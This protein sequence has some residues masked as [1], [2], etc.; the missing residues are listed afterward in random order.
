[1][2]A[3]GVGDNLRAARAE[4]RGELVANIA[5]GRVKHVIGAGRPSGV[6]PHGDG[7]HA[8]D[9]VGSGGDQAAECELSDDTEAENGSWA[10]QR[11]AGPDC[12]PETV[13]GDACQCRL[14][15]VKLFGQ[16]PE[17]PALMPHGQ[18]LVR[19]MV[20]GIANAVSRSPALD[21]GPDSHDDAGSAVA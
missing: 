10:P 19:G 15:E 20:S 12:R 16:L 5:G 11:Q 9:R 1:G 13:T 2:Y 17:P 8:N 4:C 6:A 21:A 18:Q 14:L 7:V 3:S